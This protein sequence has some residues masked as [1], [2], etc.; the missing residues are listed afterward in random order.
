MKAKYEAMLASQGAAKDQER[1]ELRAQ[2]Q[3]I[4]D[5]LKL[6]LEDEK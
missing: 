2:M 5:G 4:I 6:L 1:E 3:N